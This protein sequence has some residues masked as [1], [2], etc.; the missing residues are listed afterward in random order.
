MKTQRSL[1]LCG[2]K[3]SGDERTGLLPLAR[4]LE[5]DLKQIF[6]DLGLTGRVHVK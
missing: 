4:S 2:K 3:G 5:T 6:E 1:R